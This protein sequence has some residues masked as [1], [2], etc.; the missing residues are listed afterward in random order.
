M[1]VNEVDRGP[2]RTSMSGAIRSSDPKYRSIWNRNVAIDPFNRS[3]KLIRKTPVSLQERVIENKLMFHK[4]AKLIDKTIRPFVPKGETSIKQIYA[5]SAGLKPT[6]NAIAQ[7]L[8]F[9]GDPVDLYKIPGQ[10]MSD[11]NPNDRGTGLDRPMPQAQTATAK[12]QPL[13]DVLGS[14][15]ADPGKVKF[16]F[17]RFPVWIR[18]D[19]A[20]LNLIEAAGG[21]KDMQIPVGRYLFHFDSA[22]VKFLPNA[23]TINSPIPFTAQGKQMILEKAIIDPIT[24]QATV[25]IDV[26]ENLIPLLVV[27]AA[28]L[29]AAG[30]AGYGLSSTLK[31]VDA[32][33]VD[34]TGGAWKL[35]LALAVGVGAWYGIPYFFKRKAA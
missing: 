30:F 5:P 27:I 14:I 31:Q 16:S 24:G 13:I 32:I 10:G 35:A 19:K 18:T 21:V 26:R 22:T 23:L 29:G 15:G 11:N 12:A 34:T 17:M 2:R 7:R 33:V 28:G 25:Q 1:I 9:D 6:L 4:T 20:Q 8:K 3:T